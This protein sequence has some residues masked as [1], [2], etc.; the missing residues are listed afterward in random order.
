ML[1]VVSYD[2]PDD[3]RRLK[4]MKVLEGFGR[5][6]QFSVFECDIGPDQVDRLEKALAGAVNKDEDDVRL[7][8][9]NEADVKRVRLLGRAR[10]GRERPYE[11][12]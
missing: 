8:P 10:L 2:I 6:A 9:L 3:K 5:R 1:W 11:V 7:Y 4:V 12:V